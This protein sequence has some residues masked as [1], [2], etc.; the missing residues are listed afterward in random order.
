MKFTMSC[1]NE[2]R[3]QRITTPYRVSMSKEAGG[4][5]WT[6]VFHPVYSFHRTEPGQPVSYMDTST[7][8]ELRGKDRDLLL[9]QCEQAVTALG[10]KIVE[11]EDE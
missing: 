4:N 9:R 7:F 10:G 11:V 6:A 8:V 2:I 5:E 3:D 1:N